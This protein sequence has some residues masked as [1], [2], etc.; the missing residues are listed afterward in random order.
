MCADWE[1]GVYPV[2][3]DFNGA[4]QGRSVKYQWKKKIVA[5]RISRNPIILAISLALVV[6]IN[7]IRHRIRD[8]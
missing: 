1:S 5:G 6:N 7:G 8:W 2:E 3:F 4:A